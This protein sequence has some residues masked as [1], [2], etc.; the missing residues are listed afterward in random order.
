MMSGVP[1]LYIFTPYYFI[2][3]QHFMN[4]CSM[5]ELSHLIIDRHAKVLNTLSPYL[6]FMRM[7]Q[8]YFMIFFT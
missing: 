5:Q 4:Y 6:F 7:L 8:A 1:M 3:R 2:A